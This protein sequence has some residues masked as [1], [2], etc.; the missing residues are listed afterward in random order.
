MATTIGFGSS[1]QGTAG[2]HGAPIGH[3][4]LAAMKTTFGFDDK[5]FF[6]VPDDVGSAFR[7]EGRQQQKTFR[8]QTRPFLTQ[9]RHVRPLAGVPNNNTP[10]S[11]ANTPFSNA[12]SPL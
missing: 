7:G 3:A 12:P 11:N 2:V 4:D 1:K 9:L 6:L 5:A 8:M 10:V